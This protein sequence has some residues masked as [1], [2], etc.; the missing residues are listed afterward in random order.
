[1]SNRRRP[2]TTRLFTASDAR[3]SLSKLKYQW[4]SGYGM[5]LPAFFLLI[6]FMYYPALSAIVFSFSSWDGFNAPIFNGL[7][8]Y[9]TL[10]KDPV[11]WISIRNVAVWA[12]VKTILEI[13]IPL[14]VAV[15]IY[16]LRS[17]QM[18]YIYR[19]I[20]VVPVVVPDIVLY[21]IWSFFFDPNIGVL[22]HLFS[23]LGLAGATPNWLGDPN[24]ALFS[25]MSVG[26]PFVVPF[27][28]LIFFAGLQAI[29][30]EVMES[31][32]IEGVGRARRFFQ[33]ELPLVMGQMKLLLIL[34]MIQLLQN[35]TLP[36]VLTN[37][38]PGYSTY[39]PGLL[40]YLLAFQN[41]QFG[42][43]M[44]VSMVIFILVLS[45]TW[46]QF[47]YIRPGAEYSA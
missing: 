25:L 39:V 9:I 18:Q 31:A 11:F 30:D 27:N 22:S 4:K 17:K 28:L 42:L 36:L 3:P 41:G 16:H 19:V 26:F 6:M 10:V 33:I 8:N 43:G 47:R 35:V 46:I 5:L 34:T 32:R 45:L 1:M 24:I 40:M 21:L 15:I 7:H 13:A 14:L 37:G 2:L 23:A 38:G 12:V 29:P 44:A 20:F